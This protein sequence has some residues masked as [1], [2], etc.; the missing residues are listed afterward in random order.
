MFT[1]LLHFLF[2][3]KIQKEGLTQKKAENEVAEKIVMTDDIAASITIRMIDKIHR[4]NQPH[5]T[6]VWFCLA[7]DSVSG[8][9]EASEYLGK[10]RYNRLIAEHIKFKYSH[11]Y[12]VDKG[13]NI[14]VK[15]AF[16]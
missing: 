10:E 5:I 9:K 11:L 15:K 12:D 14:S 6:S 4:D 16:A 3:K 2:R 13:F 1:K 7:L 8:R